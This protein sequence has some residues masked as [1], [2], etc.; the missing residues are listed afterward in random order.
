ML[1]FKILGGK[2]APAERSLFETMVKLHYNPP[3]RTKDNLF[4]SAASVLKPHVPVMGLTHVVIADSSREIKPIPYLSMSRR[5]E[6]MLFPRLLFRITEWR[7]STADVDIMAVKTAL[8]DAMNEPIAGLGEKAARDLARRM[9]D[10]QQAIW[11]DFFKGME[12]EKAGA[13]LWYAMCF[14]LDEGW[15]E[16]HEGSALADGMMLMRPIF[17]KV[18][19]VE[20][21]DRS[22]RRQGYKFVEYLR[23][24]QDFRPPLGWQPSKELS[25]D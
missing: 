6:A 19:Q 22:A 9:N 21:W 1:P 8:A 24:K 12:T 25:D 10:R 5:V 20:K 7:A 3:G 13:V 18:F 2:P 14:L 16:L 17:D 4:G 15:Y 23:S 11:R